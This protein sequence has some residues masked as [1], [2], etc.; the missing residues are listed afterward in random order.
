M[1]AISHGMKPGIEEF[2]TI[3]LFLEE[4]YEQGFLK[5]SFGFRPGLS[6]HHALATVNEVVHR[7]KLSYV[8]EVIY[9]IILEV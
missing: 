2:P 7:E 1:S 8:L 5:S 6:C 4:I 9:G 3:H